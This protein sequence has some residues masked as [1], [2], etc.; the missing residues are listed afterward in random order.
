MS[1]ATTQAMPE[2]PA[3]T[4]RNPNLISV[5][6]RRSRLSKVSS[7]AREFHQDEEQEDERSPLIWHTSFDDLVRRTAHDYDL[8][9]NYER[10]AEGGQRWL[11]ED[12]ATIRNVGKHL[13]GDIFALK[14]WQ[15]V[16]AEQGDQDKKVMMYIN[17]DAKFLKLLCERVQRAINKYE[18]K[19]G[20]ELLRDGVYAQ[21]ENGNFY[22]PIPSQQHVAEGGFLQ[23][24]AQHNIGNAEGGR[25]ALHPEEHYSEPVTSSRRYRTPP[26]AYT[27]RNHMPKRNLAFDFASQRTPFDK[28]K[29]EVALQKSFTTLQSPAHRPDRV[30]NDRISKTHQGPPPGR[31]PLPL[32]LPTQRQVEATY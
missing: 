18:Q 24:V 11:P 14:R 19:C 28:F 5:V 25:P 27:S 17:R 26:K 13:H 32:P 22:K 2:P 1:G 9:M 6:L 21:D 30:L 23:D 3:E 4:L 15:R 16:V 12:I 31:H 10:D 7:P 29:E 20:F 8:V